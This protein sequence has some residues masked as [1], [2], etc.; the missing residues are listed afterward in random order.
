VPVQP[1]ELGGYGDI[2]TSQ[3]D[4]RIF[5]SHLGEIGGMDGFFVSRLRVN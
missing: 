4:V 5:P 1:N 2:I 3:G